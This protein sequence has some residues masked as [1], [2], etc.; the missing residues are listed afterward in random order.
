ME[1]TGIVMLEH[2]LAQLTQQVRNLTVGQ[3]NLLLE[4]QKLKEK[5]TSN[6]N[7]K[8]V[9]TTEKKSTRKTVVINN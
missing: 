9:D 1:H 7:T 2:K 3:Y 4:V 6:D 8:V 5:N